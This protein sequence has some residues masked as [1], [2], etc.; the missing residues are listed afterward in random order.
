MLSVVSARRPLAV[1]Y[2]QYTFGGGTSFWSTTIGSVHES[3]SLSLQIPILAPKMW[4]TRKKKFVLRRVLKWNCAHFREE[5]DKIS[6]SR[7]SQHLFKIL[8]FF[9]DKTLNSSETQRRRKKDERKRDP[10]KAK[11]IMPIC[12][13]ANGFDSPPRKLVG[14][15][16]FANRN[17]NF[18]TPSSILETGEEEWV[19]HCWMISKWSK[20]Y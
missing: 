18:K 10:K 4:S 2:V 13:M 20:N 7:A 3:Y 15:S 17:S 19:F 16:I 9:A 12:W 8:P 14:C 1:L 6:R 5:S 11:K